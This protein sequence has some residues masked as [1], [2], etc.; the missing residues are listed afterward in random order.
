MQGGPTVQIRYCRSKSRFSV[1]GVSYPHHLLTVHPPPVPSRH[2]GSSGLRDSF[3]RGSQVSVS[4]S[5]SPSPCVCGCLPDGL[6]A[7]ALVGCV[8]DGW[9]V[10]LLA[11]IAGASTGPV[12]RLTYRLPLRC[13][14]ASGLSEPGKGTMRSLRFVSSKSHQARL[15]WA[16]TAAGVSFSWDLE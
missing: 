11:T 6:G 15:S 12:S 9:A 1:S 16:M 5:D 13:L 7:G 3:S 8:C 14:L 4:G 10:G 2:Q